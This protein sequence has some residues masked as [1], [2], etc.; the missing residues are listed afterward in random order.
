MYTSLNFTFLFLVEKFK[1]NFVIKLIIEQ[2]LEK[3]Y[4]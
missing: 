2:K 4:Y 3:C 1:F